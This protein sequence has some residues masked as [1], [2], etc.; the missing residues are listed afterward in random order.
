MAATA[1]ARLGALTGRQDFESI[2]RSTLQAVQLVMEKAPTAAGQSLIVLDGLLATTREFAVT[3]GADPR[4]FREALLAIHER[5]RPHKV[6]APAP[7]GEVSL[8][9]AALVPLLAD[10]PAREGWVTT[11]LCE[12]FAC[13]APVVG[14]DAL[15]GI[16][17][18]E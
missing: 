11:Y 12:G 17:D 2:A 16:L 15:R 10:R 4:E 18:P 9:L 5:F 13:Q 7:A 1:L 3:A 14:I 8:P 6:V